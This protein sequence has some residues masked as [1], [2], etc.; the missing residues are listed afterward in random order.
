M[1]NLEWLEKAIQ[2][3]LE[4]LKQLQEEVNNEIQKH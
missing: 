4:N 3:T 2:E 1:N